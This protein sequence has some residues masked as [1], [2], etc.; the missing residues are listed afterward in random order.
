MVA[1]IGV[2][3]ASRLMDQHRFDEAESLMNH[4]LHIES[5][6]VGLHRSLLACD[7]IYLELIGENRPDKVQTLYT[8]ELKKFVRAMKTFPSVIRMEYTYRLLGQRDMQK[9]EQAL[10]AFE[11]IAATYPYP[12]DI[13]SE[14]ELI[15]IAAERAG[16]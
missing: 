5:G 13:Q 6:I 11:R 4:L 14:R 16:Q 3:A 12:N 7:L 15:Q 8:R 10:V 1:S 2:Y 9:A